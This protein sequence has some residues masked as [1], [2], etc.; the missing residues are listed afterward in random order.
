MPYDVVHDIG[1]SVIDASSFF[2]LRLFLDLCL[3]SG[4]QADDFSQELLIDLAEDIGREDGKLVR[5]IGIV[6][7]LEYIFEHFVIDKEMH[8]EFIGRFLA[9]LFGVEVKEPEL[10]RSSARSN[11]RQRR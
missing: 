6:K 11:R 4:G 9:V 10:Y 7:A 3:M 5:T 8:R 2:D 1:R